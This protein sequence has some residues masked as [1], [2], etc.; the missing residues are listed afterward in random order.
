MYTFL[1]IEQIV[2][3]HKESAFQ[4]KVNSSHH[5][6]IYQLMKEKEE[7]KLYSQKDN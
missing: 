3:Y 2:L 4:L 1:L 6:W 5:S 7:K